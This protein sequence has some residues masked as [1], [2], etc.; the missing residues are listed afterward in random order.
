[1]TMPPMAKPTPQRLQRKKPIR[2]AMMTANMMPNR[3]YAIHALPMNAVSKLSLNDAPVPGINWPTPVAMPA[4]APPMQ[5]NRFS[6][7][8]A[9]Y[10][11]SDN[12]SSMATKPSRM[13][14]SSTYM[15]IPVDVS[16][17]VP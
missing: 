15:P 8:E 4:N 17:N 5:I 2:L 3:E 14:P 13:A 9:S 7:V 6:G 16:M 12:P 10:P 11:A 1:M